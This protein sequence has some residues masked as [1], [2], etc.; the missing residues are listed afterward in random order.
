MIGACLMMGRETVDELSSK[1]SRPW[2]LIVTW[3]FGLVHAFLHVIAVYSLVFW[4]QQVIGEL[5]WIGNPNAGAW[6][7]IG[8]ASCGGLG[9]FIWGSLVGTLIFGCYLT[10]MSYFGYLTNNGYSALGI[11]DF[12]G[13]LRFKIDADATLHAHFVA[14]DRVP[15]R[16][17]RTA[18]GAP[19]W[20]PDGEAS[21]RA[22]VTRVHDRF[23][24]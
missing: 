10:L 7:A 17:K 22:I 8:H 20:E 4:L 9:V 2:R 18:S 5:R 21:A 3:G 16:W 24:L 15:R 13:F 11:Q 14:I 12:K 19:L 6:A 1:S 23:T